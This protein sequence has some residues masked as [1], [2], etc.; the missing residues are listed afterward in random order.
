MVKARALRG[1]RDGADVVFDYWRWEI[2]TKTIPYTPST[3]GDPPHRKSDEYYES[4][5]VDVDAPTLTAVIGSTSMHA[6]Y[7]EFGVS[8]DPRPAARP[9]FIDTMTTVAWAIARAF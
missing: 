5:F 4:I 1:L 2:S 3:A 6:Y 9:A 7:T 8:Y